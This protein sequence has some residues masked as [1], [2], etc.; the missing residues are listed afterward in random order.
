MKLTDTVALVTGAGKRIGRAVALEL[1]RAGCHVVVHYGRSREAAED[2]VRELADLGREAVALPA[3]LTDPHAIDT[4]FEAIGARFGRLDVL[5]NS[6]ASFERA[7]L[8]S[9]TPED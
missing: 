7:P 1:G 6:A 5:V 2:T 3:D 9:I 4:L 8:E